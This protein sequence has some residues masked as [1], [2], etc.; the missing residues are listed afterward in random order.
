M[1]GATVS[2]YAWPPSAV[3]QELRP[4]S[5]AMRKFIVL[6][7]TAVAA[8]VAMAIPAAASAA[9]RPGGTTVT[10]VLLKAIAFRGGANTQHPAKAPA[11][12]TC[13]PLLKGDAFTTGRDK[14]YKWPDGMTVSGAGGP[15][16][17]AARLTGV[18]SWLWSPRRG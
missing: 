7:A 17:Q 14:A 15:G 6:A 16:R 8:T 2:L 9:T 10:E 18:A 5:F 11:A 3:L 12:G 4:S 13:L 1:P